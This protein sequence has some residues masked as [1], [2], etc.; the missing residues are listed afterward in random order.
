MIHLASGN[1]MLPTLIRNLIQIPVVM[2]AAMDY[3][4]KKL[5]QTMRQHQEILGALR[6]GDGAWAEAAMRSHVLSARP[7]PNTA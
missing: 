7:T 4:P 3:T 6:T 5:I 2:R 1:S